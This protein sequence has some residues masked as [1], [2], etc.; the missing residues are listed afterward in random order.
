MT[1]YS[2]QLY[3]DY[4]DDF[5]L[6]DNLFDIVYYCRLHSELVVDGVDVRIACVL[7]DDDGAVVHTYYYCAFPDGVTGD[8]DDLI[9]VDFRGDPLC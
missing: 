3:P 1:M 2:L 8:V 5:Y 4:M 7:V 6:A 9:E